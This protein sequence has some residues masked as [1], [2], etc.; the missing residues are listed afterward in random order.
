M[1]YDQG[2]ADLAS[3][4]EDRGRH[5]V[6]ADWLLERGDPRGEALALELSGGGSKLRALQKKHARE[7]LGPAFEH[8]ELER[9]AFYGAFPIKLSFKRG[10]PIA[11]VPQTVRHLA[12][13]WRQLPAVAPRRFEVLEVLV[14]LG[15]A[16]SDFRALA[17][18]LDEVAKVKAKRLLL[19]L[20]TF[21]GAEAAQFLAMGLLRSGL[22]E[23]DSVTFIVRDGSMD[24]AAAWLQQADSWGGGDRWGAEWQGAIVTVSRDRRGYF[25][26]LEVDLSFDDDRAIAARAAS[27]AMVLSQLRRMN[28]SRLDVRVADGQRFARRLSETFKAPLRFLPGIGKVRVIRTSKKSSD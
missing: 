9:C 13:D 8:V 23:Q 27:A 3:H 26:E 19:V 21:A 25:R 15:M 12:G 11:D 28:P 14:G 22:A 16:F 18:E 4:P 17:E 1:T 2:V 20:D 6:F 10:A 24:A 5:A 7:W